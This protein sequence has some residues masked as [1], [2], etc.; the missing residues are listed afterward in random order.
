LQPDAAN[1]NVRNLLHRGIIAL[2]LSAKKC[3]IPRNFITM[4][5]L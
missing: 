2:E 3:P 1:W 5:N 4:R